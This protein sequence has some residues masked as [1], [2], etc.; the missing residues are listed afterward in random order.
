MAFDLEKEEAKYREERASRFTNNTAKQEPVVD[1]SVGKPFRETFMWSAFFG[2]PIVSYIAHLSEIRRSGKSYFWVVLG[3]C[4]VP[5]MIV[6]GID[7][8]IEYAVSKLTVNSNYVDDTYYVYCVLETLMLIAFN[9]FMAC[10]AAWRF[11][12]ICP[13]YDAD[14]YQQKEK[15]G[16]IAGAVLWLI[17]CSLYFF[18]SVR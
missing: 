7:R 16:V 18:S 14:D 3:I 13:Y 11:G 4:L 2:G 12:K 8:G 15:R 10:V 5:R 1:E 17:L 6:N 9:L